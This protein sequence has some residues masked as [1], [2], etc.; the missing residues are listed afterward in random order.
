MADFTFGDILGRAI[1]RRSQQILNTLEDPV[2]AFQE[3]ANAALGEETT[4]A[5]TY[6]PN[7]GPTVEA[8]RGQ[9]PVNPLN[10]DAGAGRGFVNP[11]FAL[12]TPS[13]VAPAP[14]APV[15]SA[16]VPEDY[17]ARIAQ[18]ESGG[19]QDIGYHNKAK[20]SAY[21]PYGI[22]ASAYQDA[23]RVDPSLP[24]DIAQATPQ[25]MTQAQNAFTNANAGYLK[26]YGVPVNE[27]TLSAA[28]FL[29]AKG[30][31]DYLRDGTISPAAARAN[32]GE[33]N[34]R[35]IVQARLGG[36]YAPASGAVQPAAAPQAAPAT[37][38]VTPEAAAAQPAPAAVTTGTQAAPEVFTGQGL[39]VP[40]P[41]AQ[42]EQN[43]Y[44]VLNSNDQK[45]LMGLA[46]DLSTPPNIA[47]M[48]MDRLHTDIETT[49]KVQK[50]EADLAKFAETQNPTQLVRAMNDKDTGSYFKAYLFK[51]LGLDE[52][53]QQE[54]Q[55]ISPSFT[56]S[57]VTLPSGEN[58]S[59]KF[60]KSTG[61]VIGA[62]DA[63]GAPVRDPKVLG[64][65]AA[66]AVATKNL[67]Q[68]GATFYRDS[69]GQQWSQVPGPTGARFINVNT[70]QVG[71]PEGNI[72]PITA[73][74][75]LE[76]YFKKK[77]MDL[78]ARLVGA[79]QEARI[80]AYG[81]LNNE[82]VLAGLPPMAPEEMGV[83]TTPALQA[84]GTTAPA[85]Q[86]G[87]VP[88]APTTAPAAAGGAVS[89][90][91]AAQIP[92]VAA[93]PAPAVAQPAPTG[94]Q[95]QAGRE[96]TKQAAAEFI[97]YGSEDITPKA[98]AGGTVARI[99]K[100]Q[101]N[102]P[103]GILANPE[104]AGILQGQGGA[105]TEVLNILRDTITGNFKDGDELS[106][107]VNSLNL[108]QRQKDIVNIQIGLAR[109]V[110]PQTLKQNAGP[111]AVS[112]AEQKAN[113]QANVDIT[114]QPLYTGLTLMT[115]SQFINDLAVARAEFKAAR[116]D[117]NTT[118]KFNSAWNA[119]K[120]RLNKEYD[121]IYEERAKYI[122]RY[123][124]DGK[125]PGAVVD[126]YKYYPV[127]EYDSDR[128]QWVYGGYSDKA[129]RPKLD[130]FVR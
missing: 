53:A 100:Q 15:A 37:A 66:S 54:Q 87:A 17:N 72:V 19:R 88:P 125:N 99:R 80:K 77:Q 63:T 33:E 91:A 38:P 60:N 127:P 13:Q 124:K 29:G 96:A 61:E 12:Q 67:G 65:I 31:A 43:Y 118:E 57:P 18:A 83:S 115:R 82:R 49:R 68:S 55:K 9:A 93:A 8:G 117:L 4:T 89:P 103:D 28:H 3:R 47:R 86:A 48:A 1:Q 14:A 110:D 59:V 62:N 130:S 75:D 104:L 64:Q 10:Q 79:T 78:N 105:G 6:R 106:R 7:L 121:A 36:Q 39:R 21:G 112:D 32:G 73:G 111:G 101:I 109:Q 84:P 5:T 122:A 120:A 123:N 98:D 52:L 129:K 42:A 95:L 97:K 23:R 34:A 70:G 128:K 35:K 45:A 116:P 56:Y 46:Y 41:T 44:S 126:A 20:S 69:K 2:G 114:R 90:Q 107:R 50:A 76:T 27:Q 40:T 102:G 74:S 16:A 25:Q 108:T 51:R 94:A 113:R 119:E 58:Y 11:R 30:L 92:Q 22:T 85:P 26:N 24:E 71:R 81:D